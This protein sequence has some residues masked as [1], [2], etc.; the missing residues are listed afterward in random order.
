[1]CNNWLLKK[2]PNKLHIC[3][4]R[5]SVATGPARLF[6]GHGDFFDC[7]RIPHQNRIAHSAYASDQFND[8]ALEY[9]QKDIF[10][11]VINKLLQE[12]DEKRQNILI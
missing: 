11:R 10:C 4:N 2:K 7:E 8:S 12:G 3:Y 1:M 9:R 5:D 6:W